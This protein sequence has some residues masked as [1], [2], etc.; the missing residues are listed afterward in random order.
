[1][2]PYSVDTTNPSKIGWVRIS[3]LQFRNEEHKTELWAFVGMAHA[4]AK[5]NSGQVNMYVT[6]F[7]A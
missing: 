2:Q 7:K 6:V 3:T 5:L 1:M 4:D